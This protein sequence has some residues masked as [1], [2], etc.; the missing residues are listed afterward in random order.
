MTIS[1]KEQITGLAVLVLFIL[2]CLT[3]SVTWLFSDSLGYMILGPVLASLGGILSAQSNSSTIK[4]V[5]DSFVW[6]CILGIAVGMAYGL[7]LLKQ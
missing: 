6:L 7:F 4:R 1:K 5:Q 2:G 3:T